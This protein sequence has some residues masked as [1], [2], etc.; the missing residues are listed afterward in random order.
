MRLPT[1]SQPVATTTD[2][3]EVLLFVCERTTKY[4]ATVV[5]VVDVVVIFFLF[6]FLYQKL[7]IQNVRVCLLLR[8][9]VARVLRD[10]IF[11]RKL[12]KYI[13]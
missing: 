3:W 2:G 12:K 10:R 9:F 7:R 11:Y 4:S 6:F 8:D 5:V 13:K 1:I